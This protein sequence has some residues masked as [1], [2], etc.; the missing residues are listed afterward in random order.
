MEDIRRH[1]SLIQLRNDFFY[2]FGIV[3]LEYYNVIGDGITDN[4]LQLQQAINDA[5][6]NKIK[7]IFVPKGEYYYS[8]SLRDAEQIIWVGNSAEAYI[9]GVEIKQFP[10]LWNESQAN[11]AGL[12]PIG[13]VILYAGTTMPE[14]YLLCDGSTKSREEYSSLFEIIGTPEEK[15]DPEGTT[16]TLPTATSTIDRLQYIIRAK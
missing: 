7:Y 14:G 13:S 1:T 15:A 6:I 8:N 11:A 4:R 12:I 9:E 16:F 10:D 2:T 5:I 3:P